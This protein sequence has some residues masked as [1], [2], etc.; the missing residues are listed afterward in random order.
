LR[1]PGSSSADTTPNAFSFTDQTDVALASVITSA[2]VPI[3]GI[4]TAVGWTASGG[5]VCVSATGD[6]GFCPAGY[7]TSGTVVS[8]QFLCARHDSASGFSTATDTLVTVGGVSDTFTS[9]TLADSG[10]TASKS[11]DLRVLESRTARRNGGNSRLA[12]SIR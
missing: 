3:A 1:R 10:L 8:S 11:V 9:T 7:T 2:P 6:C 12:D 4:N 5:T